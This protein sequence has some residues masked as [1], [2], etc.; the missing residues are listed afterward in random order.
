MKEEKN[1]YI[2]N[3]IYI[4]R[5]GSRK[6][7]QPPIKL[8][9]VATLSNIFWSLSFFSID[10]FV[11]KYTAFAKSLTKVEENNRNN[12]RSE[13]SSVFI[14]FF[15]FSDSYTEQKVNK[16]PFRL[17]D[18]LHRNCIIHSMGTSPAETIAGRRK[19]EKNSFAR[20]LANKNPFKVKKD[21]I[22]RNA[23]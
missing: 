11:T 12:K 7:A 5:I 23:I 18:Q 15:P 2:Y 6:N 1:M 22:N 17:G 21:E 20:S 10:R 13:N 16:R 8:S 14:L 3:Y 19:R 9:R 4:F